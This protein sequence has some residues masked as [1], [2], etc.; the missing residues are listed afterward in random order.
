MEEAYGG[1]L[2][3]VKS[4][5]FDPGRLKTAWNKNCYAVGLSQ[6]FVEPLEATSI[7]SVI[8]Q[9][10]CFIHYLPSYDINTCNK[11]VNEIFDNIFDFVQ[12]HYLV[13][14]EDTIFWKEIK[15]NL[16][17]TDNLQNYLELWKNRL[18]HSIDSNCD[19]SLF[20]PAN[21]IPILYGLGWFNIDKI[22]EEYVEYNIEKQIEEHLRGCVEDE[23]S[24]IWVKHKEMVDILCATQQSG[25]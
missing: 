18:P 22:R 2:N 4:F 8:Q 20:S 13:K 19:W 7:G 14:R 5:K 3:G 17:L 24:L 12:S 25:Y 15:Y 21:Y 10:F 1:K 6:S 23:S 16:K 9:M 11:K